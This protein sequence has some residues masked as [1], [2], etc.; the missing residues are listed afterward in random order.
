MITPLAARRGLITPLGRGIQRESAAVSW[1]LSGGISAANCIAAYQAKGA[2]DYAASKVNLAS[3]GT[4]N[5]VDGAQYP[6]WASATGW[7][8]NG[9]SQYLNSGVVPTL[10]QTWS[11]IV[12]QYATYLDNDSVLFSRSG[13]SLDF[14]IYQSTAT[15]FFPHNSKNVNITITSILNTN[16]VLAVVGRRGYKDGSILT[17]EI[18]AYTGTGT[19]PCYIGA[20]N[21]AGSAGIFW[22]GN[23]LAVAIYNITLTEAQVL[24]VTTAMNAL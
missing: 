9:S 12:R 5:A 3:P 15:S 20:G 16:A 11:A 19:Q 21:L 10:D 2:A 6:T 8:F 23:V 4:Y 17:G 7:T 1:W 14:G 13:S 22:K 18:A 24:A